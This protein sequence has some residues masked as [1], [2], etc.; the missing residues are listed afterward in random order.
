MIW[1]RSTMMYVQ[2]RYRGTSWHRIMF[3]IDVTVAL[4]GQQPCTTRDLMLTGPGM[5][6]MALPGCGFPKEIKA[7]IVR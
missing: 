7:L 4:S 1:C 6:L 3:T 2:T 5:C